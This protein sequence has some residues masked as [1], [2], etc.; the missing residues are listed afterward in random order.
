MSFSKFR[1]LRNIFCIWLIYMVNW[2]LWKYTKY[3]VYLRVQ[4]DWAKVLHTKLIWELARKRYNWGY[5]YLCYTLQ[6][7]TLI[8]TIEK[9]FVFTKN[10][11]NRG[12]QSVRLSKSRGTPKKYFRGKR[13]SYKGTSKR[14][15]WLWCIWGKPPTCIIK[16]IS[17]FLPYQRA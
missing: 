5:K 8:V 17:W 6:R 10:N 11:H 7:A 15:I 4:L 9:C 14:N 16:I 13:D 2:S 1:I 12:R 3:I